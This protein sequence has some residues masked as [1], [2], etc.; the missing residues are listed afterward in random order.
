MIYIDTMLS[1]RRF[2]H[3]AAAGACA[4]LAGLSGCASPGASNGG[5]SSKPSDS[6]TTSSAIEGTAEN[7]S[8]TTVGEVPS[9]AKE[10]EQISN[11][12]FVFDTVVTLTASCAQETLD[13][14]CERCKYFESI[15]SRT[16]E[17]SDIG[18]INAAGGKPVQ[19]AAETAD[20]ITRALRYCAESEGRFDIS[21]GSVSTLWDFKEGI[22]P[23]AKDLAEAVKH[24]DYTKVQVEGT[25]VTLLDPQAKLDLGGIAKGYIADDIARLFLEAGCNSATINLGGNVK[26]VGVRPDGKAWRVG[27][28]DPN[29]LDQQVVAAVESQDTSVVTSGL[30]ER[31][32]E[33]GGKRYWHILD[34]KTGY[35]VKTDLVSTSIVSSDSIDGDAYA[36]MLFAMGHDGALKWF[37]KHEGFEGMAVDKDG[38]I[39]QSSG[40]DAELL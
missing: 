12:I 4:A 8:N 1:R 7:P 18:R 13:A 28:Q 33:K 2:L 29:G 30:Y 38:T 40:C 20:I 25:T 5:A 10:H 17:E 3:L 21:I 24:I 26:T 19:V 35:P 39:T 15:F 11:T 9:A 14:A 37:E 31:Q 22:V 34:P 36:T 23:D 16:I 32:F 27:I 6:S